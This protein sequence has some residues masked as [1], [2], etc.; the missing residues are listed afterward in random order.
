MTKYVVMTAYVG[1]QYANIVS[2]ELSHP[3]AL[4]ECAAFTADNGNPKRHYWIMAL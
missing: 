2:G 1:G 3:E 4:T